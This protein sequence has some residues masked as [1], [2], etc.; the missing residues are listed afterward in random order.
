MQ[1]LLFLT[2]NPPLVFQS[3]ISQSNTWTH[4]YTETLHVTLVRQKISVKSFMKLWV[5]INSPL[6]FFHKCFALQAQLEII[7]L[8]FQGEHHTGFQHPALLTGLYANLSICVDHLP[9]MQGENHAQDKVRVLQQPRKSP[10]RHVP[11]PPGATTH[12]PGR[13]DAPG[14]DLSGSVTSMSLPHRGVDSSRLPPKSVPPRKIKIK[15]GGQK[16]DPSHRL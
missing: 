6:H 16:A 11:N 7:V 15:R 1:N 13:G 2:G 4:V 3:E 14:T 10:Q 9:E 5:K 8:I 12:P